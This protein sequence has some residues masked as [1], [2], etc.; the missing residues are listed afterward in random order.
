MLINQGHLEFRQ[1]AYETGF[2]AWDLSS[3][4][5]DR[6]GDLDIVLAMAG[7][8]ATGDVSILRN[9]GKGRFVSVRFSSGYNPHD[10]AIADFDGDSRADIVVTQG[11]TSTGSIHL[12]RRHFRFG[13]PDLFETDL[14]VD[15]VEHADVDQDDD[16]DLTIA[17]NDPFGGIGY[18]QVMNNF[19]KAKF[20]P[21]QLIDSGLT[22][23]GH[24]GHVQPADIN[25]DGW[26]DLV[27]NLSQFSEPVGPIVTSL[28]DGSGN[29]GPSVVF[30]GTARNDYMAVADL[31]DDG[32]LDLASAQFTEQIAIYL[33]R[34]DG[35]FGAAKIVR[36]AEFPGMIV[37]ADL[38]GDGLVDLATVHNGVYGSS[39]AISVLRG[40]GGGQFASAV[41]YTVGQGPIEIVATDLDDDGD[42]DLATSNNG[43]DD[44]STFAPESTTVLLNKGD[45]KFGPITTYAGEAVYNYLSE[46]A[47]SA[48]DIDGDGHID[49]AVSNVLGNDIGVYYGKGDGTLAPQQVRYGVQNG[50]Q[51]MTLADFNGDGS[52]DIAAAGY[53]QSVD[54]LFPPAGI[55][56]LTNRGS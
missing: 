49:I 31:D 48:A 4:D 17:I 36:V 40:T 28:N 14:L 51:D 21:G 45:G 15:S 32:D 52:V 29:Y 46:W 5:L 50:A 35:T 7:S 54:P 38:S 33:N 19:G 20:Q 43:G 8:S 23:D 55:V 37:A 30:P 39:K 10:V 18:V 1:D 12:Q 26:D 24:V 25:G 2:S 9:T 41:T 44:T 6:D 47:I 11:G 34:G 16:V 56:V 42:L 3:G 22:S 27:W 53:L 13:P